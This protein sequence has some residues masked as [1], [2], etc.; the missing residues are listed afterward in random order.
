MFRSGLGVLMGNYSHYVEAQLEKAFD[1]IRLKHVL[2]ILRDLGVPSGMLSLIHNIYTHNY[3]RIKIERKLEGK[4]PVKQGIRQG[5]SLSPLLFNI[6]M[7]DIIK[8]LR[9]LQGYPL[10]DENVN[11]ICY[12]DDTTLIADKT[13]F[14]GS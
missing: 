13:I 3:A 12:T 10:G 5:D 2:N 9:D 4:M 11:I 1:K 8:S 6:V 7:N 14:N